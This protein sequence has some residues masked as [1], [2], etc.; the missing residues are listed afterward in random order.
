MAY[1]FNTSKASI[2][3]NEN[4]SNLTENLSQGYGQALTGNEVQ[5]AFK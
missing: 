4:T 5:M 3:N 1:I 2:I